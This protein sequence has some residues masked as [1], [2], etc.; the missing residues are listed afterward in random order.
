MARRLKI[1]RSELTNVNYQTLGAFRLRVD[2]TDPD[3]SGADVNVFL[4]NRRPFNPHTEEALSDF[5]AVAS[6]VDLAEYP[7]GEPHTDTAYPFFRLS[8]VELDFRAV[9]QADET[10]LLLVA[11]IDA[12]LKALDALENL[13]VTQ[14]VWV[15]SETTTG[16]SSSGV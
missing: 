16:S 5:M 14:E 10:W 12:L 3:N 13:T 15:G 6:A 1:S 2:V 7:V 4:Y 11:E 8:Y 9:S